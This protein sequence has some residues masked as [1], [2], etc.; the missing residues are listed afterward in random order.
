MAGLLLWRRRSGSS[1][2]PRFR[3][4]WRIQPR[5]RFPSTK[6]KY[7]R[8]YHWR[9]P[10]RSRC[11]T[12]L[13]NFRVLPYVIN[14]ICVCNIT[15]TLH[16]INFN[17]GC[18]YCFLCENTYSVNNIGET[19]LF[20]THTVSETG[21]NNNNIRCVKIQ[22]PSY[23]LYIRSTRKLF[24]L[25]RREMQN[26]TCN[27]HVSAL[28]ATNRAARPVVFRVGS[29]FELKNDFKRDTK[30]WTTQLRFLAIANYGKTITR[31]RIFFIKQ[32]VLRGRPPKMFALRLRNYDF[33]H[34]YQLMFI[35]YAIYA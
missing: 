14:T 21:K 23:V 9:S 3:D 27:S 10:S 4:E 7:L 8:R 29:V 33:A 25:V 28:T 1:W 24:C 11:S 13:F 30:M 2:P 12:L 32:Q 34:V 31:G 26:D 16:A 6:D 18:F 5:L 20:S 17:N 19:L 22:Y 15:P 35:R